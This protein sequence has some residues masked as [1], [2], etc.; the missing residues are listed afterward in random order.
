MHGP[1]RRHLFHYCVFSLCLGSNST[2]LLHCRLF[3]QLLPS[4]GS[5]CHTLCSFSDIALMPPIPV[6]YSPTS[7]HSSRLR[8]SYSIV[9]ACFEAVQAMTF[10]RSFC[11]ICSALHMVFTFVQYICPL[12]RLGQ[13]ANSTTFTRERLARSPSPPTDIWQGCPYSR[14]LHSVRLHYL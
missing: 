7:S 14:H 1:H 8:K 5:A 13:G 3:T 2:E 9:K 11:W 6:S 4:K 12:C 10:V